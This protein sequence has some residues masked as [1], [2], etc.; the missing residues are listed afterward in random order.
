M[1]RSFYQI[2]LGRD[3]IFLEGLEE[4][5]R[6]ARG[7]D[8]VLRAVHEQHRRAISENVRDGIGL[9][10]AFRAGQDTAVLSAEHGR[11]IYPQGFRCASRL[12]S[13]FHGFT[14]VVADA[15][16]VGKAIEVYRCFYVAPDLEIIALVKGRRAAGRRG[17]GREIAT[18]TAADDADSFRVDAELV[19]MG[20]Q[21]TDRGFYIFQGFWEAG[22]RGYP[23][24]DGSDDIAGFC[25]VH[26]ELDAV[27]L[28]G[29]DEAAA[30]DIYNSR[31][32]FIR[33]RLQDVHF[34]GYVGVASHRDLFVYDVGNLID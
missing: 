1:G 19:C 27:V 12:V 28:I 18:G 29:I 4:Q 9:F 17:H 3:V 14:V 10:G 34:H 22:R 30:G 7:D 24:L 13:F 2:P 31:K 6:L 26:P 23:V 21:I 8:G 20:F 33:F 16:K 15:G 5:V 32:L 25:Q 11:A